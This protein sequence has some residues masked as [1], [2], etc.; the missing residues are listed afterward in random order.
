MPRFVTAKLLGW[1]SGGLAVALI[2][3]SIFGYVQTGR[4]NS[5][6]EAVTALKGQVNAYLIRI[7]GDAQK[8]KSRDDLIAEQNTAVIAIQKASEADRVAYQA[9]IAAAQKV[10]QTYQRRAADIMAR[11]LDSDD[12]LTRCREAAKLLQEEMSNAV[13]N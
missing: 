2:A 7:K 11:Q 3:A 6:N 13:R 9:R 10:A 8:I 1:L 12:E 4:L 5:A